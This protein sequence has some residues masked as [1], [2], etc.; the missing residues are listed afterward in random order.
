VLYCDVSDVT[1]CHDAV[2]VV[3][4]CSPAGPTSGMSTALLTV[5]CDTV[6]VDVL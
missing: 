1:R 2:R 5:D 3:P 4:I 6:Y